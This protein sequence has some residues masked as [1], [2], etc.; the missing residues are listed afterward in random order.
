M[1][2]RNLFGDLRDTLRHFQSVSVP[3]KKRGRRVRTTEPVP[4]CQPPK[5]TSDVLEKVRAQRAREYYLW[6]CEELIQ[7]KD[8]LPAKE[9][10]K[11]D[12]YVASLKPHEGS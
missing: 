6:A 5:V 1:K 9:Y 3:K 8:R 7:W 2:D 10:A 4:M 12:A 11:L